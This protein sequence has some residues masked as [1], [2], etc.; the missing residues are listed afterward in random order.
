MAVATN[1]EECTKEPEVPMCKEFSSFPRKIHPCGGRKEIGHSN[2]NLQEPHD[3]QILIDRGKSSV[4]HV[5]KVPAA[6]L[7]HRVKGSVGVR[8][9]GKSCLVW[10]YR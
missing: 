6:M 8:N 7:R 1:N 4:L 9:T 3:M 10:A 5:G 2:H